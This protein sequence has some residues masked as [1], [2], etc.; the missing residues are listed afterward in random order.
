MWTH[1]WPRAWIAHSTPEPRRG[2][3]WRDKR[4]ILSREASVSQF[5][6]DRPTPALWGLRV[7]LPRELTGPGLPPILVCP[8]A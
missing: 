2:R 5:S 8:V 3:P 6:Q 4:S 1:A 7:R